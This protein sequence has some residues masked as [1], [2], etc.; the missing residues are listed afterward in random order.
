MDQIPEQAN[1]VALT[2]EQ[3]DAFNADGFLRFGKLLDDAEIAE[4]KK[5]YRDQAADL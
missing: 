2:R 4:L 3:I 1:G 5:Q